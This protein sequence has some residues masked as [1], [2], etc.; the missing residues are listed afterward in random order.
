MLTPAQI[1]DSLGWK[2]VPKRSLS[3]FGVGGVDRGP[4]FPC[5]KAFK[6]YSLQCISGM[7]TLIWSFVP[8]NMQ[9]GSSWRSGGSQSL[10]LGTKTLQWGKAS[11]ELA[12]RRIKPALLKDD[13]PNKR[14][15]S[16][17]YFNGAAWD[18]FNILPKLV[19]VK[20]SLLLA[21]P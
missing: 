21:T 17:I 12:A 20:D 19:G 14:C 8:Q 7:K 10:F 16:S 11:K 1:I 15:L 4:H 3:F 2:T 18:I 6:T 5:A 13:Y 9:R